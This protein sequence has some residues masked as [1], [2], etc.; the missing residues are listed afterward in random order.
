MELKLELEHPNPPPKTPLTRKRGPYGDV[1]APTPTLVALPPAPLKSA[2]TGQ[3]TKEGRVEC[4]APVS[5]IHKK[6]TRA[7]V[8][9]ELPIIRSLKL[10]LLLDWYVTWARGTSGSPMP[11]RLGITV[12][13]AMRKKVWL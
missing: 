4:D 8:E 10:R 6:A 7:D 11:T 2:K 5:T 9:K 1:A 13:P 3:G 12:G